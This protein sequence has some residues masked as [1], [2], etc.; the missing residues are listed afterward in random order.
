MFPNLHAVL[1]LSMSFCTSC[2][3]VLLTF[4]H[5]TD[6]RSPSPLF[7]RLSI[8]YK[9]C[10]SA[11]SAFFIHEF[12]L[13]PVKLHPSSQPPV[14]SAAFRGSSAPSLSQAQPSGLQLVALVRASR[15]DL[16]TISRSIP[17]R[18]STCQAATVRAL[19]SP[20]PLG[21]VCQ[22]LALPPLA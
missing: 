16:R 6:L 11:S 20:Q 17:I 21:T 12:V 14:T 5:V 8:P 13:A 22:M 2:P 18:A 10:L 7:S 9:T 15:A 1:Q 3:L 19:L 4:P